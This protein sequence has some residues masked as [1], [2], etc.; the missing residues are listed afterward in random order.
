LFVTH[1]IDGRGNETL[2]TYDARGNRT[3]T[4][5]RVPSVM[6]DFEYNA[7]GQMTAHVLPDN[8]TG[9]RRRDEFTYYT[10]GP[11][12]GYLHTA[13]IDA[14]SLALTATYEYDSAGN[15]VREIDFRGHDTLY[16][17]NQLDQVVRQ[18]SRVASAGVRYQTDIYYNADD[19]VVRTDVQNIDEAGVLQPNS[20]ITTIIEHDILSGRNGWS[21]DSPLSMTCSCSSCTVKGTPGQ[22]GPGSLPFP[23]NG[24]GPFLTVIPSRPPTPSPRP[25]GDPRPRDKRGVVPERDPNPAQ[26]GTPPSPRLGPAHDPG[27][28]AH[29]TAGGAGS[30]I[31]PLPTLPIRI[32]QETGSFTAPIPGLPGEPDTSLLPASEFAT[33]EIVYDANRNAT[34]VRFGEAFEGRQP[35]NVVRILNDERDLPFRE[36]R[37]EGDLRQSTTQLDYDR[38]GNRVRVSQGLEDGA[39]HVATAIV[40]GYDRTV[41]MTNP[42]GN[43]ETLAFDANS[44]V[45]SWRIDGELNDVPGS[46]ANVRMA[47]ETYV[48]DPMDRV[49][50]VEEAFFDPA[51]QAPIGDGSSVTQY[52]WSGTSQ[53]TRVTDDNGHAT[54]YAYDGANRPAI[55]TDAAG[56]TLSYARDANGNVTSVT[57]VEKSD[58]G[59]PDQS[60]TTQYTYD[61]LDRTIVVV[62]NAGNHMDYGYD[63]RS[64]LT[65]VSDARRAT[66]AAPGNL[67]RFAYD[68]RGLL[69]STTRYLTSDGTGGGDPAGFGL[70]R[71]PKSRRGFGAA[72][73]RPE[74]GV[75]PARPPTRPAAHPVPRTRAN[76]SRSCVLGRNETEAPPENARCHGFG[77]PFSTRPP[78]MAQRS[79]PRNP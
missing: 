11:Q 53:I 40:D 66:Q 3:H 46:A 51:T 63:S 54:Q 68:A 4:Q 55:E 10:T 29:P 9:H 23:P 45:T 72:P 74:T 62:D 34:L 22:F 6:E 77:R 36:I 75:A 76:F 30:G 67:T 79:R 1:H 26:S 57:S 31:P 8:G 43:V 50:R 52:V 39:P 24:G 27:S 2:H 60:F 42:M 21:N 37:A 64:D 73:S 16:T 18:T 44:N 28:E 41:M 48:D 32:W 58:T 47:E 49:T 15:P 20:Q 13:A 70:P 5:H 78:P 71:R 7:F 35:T 25:P 33:T 69:I 59:Q 17:Y 38:N 56:N 65:L 61:N 14:D 12:N 19:N